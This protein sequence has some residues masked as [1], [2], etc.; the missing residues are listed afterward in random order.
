VPDPDHWSHELLPEADGSCRLEI[1]DERGERWPLARQIGPA[2]ARAL[3][4]AI[5]Q[6][7]ARRRWAIAEVIRDPAFMAPLII[8]VKRDVRG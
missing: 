6:E 5:E 4:A 7:A 8:A 2:Q 1:V 3:L